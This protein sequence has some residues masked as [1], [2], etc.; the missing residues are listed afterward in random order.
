MSSDENLRA[1]DDDVF[2]ALTDAGDRSKRKKI[3]RYF[4]DLEE[5]LELLEGLIRRV[6]PHVDID[7]EVGPSFNRYTWES[8]KGSSSTYIIEP[9]ASQLPSNV[10]S[11]APLSLSA[12][13]SQTLH[14][15]IPRA[16]HTKIDGLEDTDSSDNER[17]LTRNDGT[18]MGHLMETHMQ[19]LH[20]GDTT[21][22]RFLGKSAGISLVRAALAL[23]RDISGN[24]GVNI[25]AIAHLLGPS[26]PK[27]WKPSPV[28]GPF[29]HL[30]KFLYLKLV[31]LALAYNLARTLIDHYFS[32][33]SPLFPVVFRP[34]FEKQ[35]AEENYRTDLDF[36]RLLLVVCS[37]GARYCNDTRVCL[38][39]SE[40]ALDWNSAGWVYFRQVHQMATPAKLVDLQVMALSA[41]YLEGTSVSST[42]WLVNGLALRLGEDLGIHREKVYAEN[43]TFLNQLWKR[44]FWCLVQ[45]DRMLSA[46]LG[47]PMCSYDEDID[48]HLPLEV[49][50]EG[51][52]ESTQSWIQP[53]GKPSQLSYFIQHS[54]LLEI[55]THAMRTLYSIKKLKVRLG[56]VGP[57]WE[58]DK[59]A[60][61][62]SAL[63]SWMER[64]PLYLKYD[65]HMETPFYQ[66]AVTLRIMFHYVQITIHRPFLQLSSSSRRALSLSSL[67]VCANAARS[68]AKVLNEAIDTAASPL[69]SIAALISGVVLLISIW[70][71]RRS[72]LSVD[73]SRQTAGIQACLRYLKRWEERGSFRF[74]TVAPYQ[75]KTGLKDVVDADTGQHTLTT[76]EP[77]LSQ[78]SPGSGFISTESAPDSNLADSGSDILGFGTGIQPLQGVDLPWVNVA[79]NDVS[80]DGF[81]RELLGSLADQNHRATDLQLDQWNGDPATQ[82]DWVNSLL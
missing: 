18:D 3:S 24:P 59:V 60:E 51:W 71:A 6:A 41:I 19:K 34:L 36:A 39:S 23:K 44:V 35:Y 65:Q 77:L 82:W 2:R 74:V 42:A 49:D 9:S 81:W 67:A 20:L 62:D 63:N 40:G 26:R 55:L 73:V 4:K 70:E 28:G 75:C 30:R 80:P 78:W 8:I 52:D 13:P 10:P 50:D 14:T 21:E 72:G 37:V 64:L 33:V 22:K 32:D 48:A 29:I 58:Q 76:R 47:R 5:R 7:K 69:F 25:P 66:Q 27:F 43:H 79:M 11:F 12:V 53:A 1:S 45:R 16:L 31:F 68:C 46:V 38:T 17:N 61:L 15:P 56:F 54:K 57:D